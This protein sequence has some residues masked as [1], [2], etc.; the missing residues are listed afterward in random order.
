MRNELVHR[1]VYKTFYADT[2][3]DIDHIDK[4]RSNNAIYNLVA[5]TKS[6]N[7]SNRKEIYIISQ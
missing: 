2:E 4:D 1:L 5:V 6:E 7:N 3:L